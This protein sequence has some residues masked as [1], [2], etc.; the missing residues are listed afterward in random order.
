[1]MSSSYFENVS[2]LQA[3][4]RQRAVVYWMPGFVPCV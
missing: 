1:M 4:S 3:V 2:I